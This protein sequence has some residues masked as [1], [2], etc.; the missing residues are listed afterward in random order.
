MSTHNHPTSPG[1]NPRAAKRQTFSVPV[2]EQGLI[3]TWFGTRK[4]LRSYDH[5]M[6][7]SRLSAAPI[8]CQAGLEREAEAKPP[9]WGTGVSTRM[10][11][12]AWNSFHLGVGVRGLPGCRR[13]LLWAWPLFQH[14]WH[15]RRPALEPHPVKGLDSLSL[16]EWIV[17]LRWLGRLDLDHNLPFPLPLKP[18]VFSFSG[19]ETITDCF[20]LPLCTKVHKVPLTFMTVFYFLTKTRKPLSNVSPRMES[21]DPG[22]PLLSYGPPAPV[23][24][25][26][27]RGCLESNSQC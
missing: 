14:R 22:G 5:K 23:C 11:R 16:R 20:L 26:T 24:T 6:N 19:G 21:L 1:F 4:V 13:F 9:G 2:V 25:C 7:C 18:A 10:P 17:G 15:R 3:G 27:A 8:K 12:P